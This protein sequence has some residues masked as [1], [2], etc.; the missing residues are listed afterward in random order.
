[1]ELPNTQVEAAISLA[2]G[3]VNEGRVQSRETVL[4]FPQVTIDDEHLFML[5]TREE[6]Q[7]YHNYHSRNARMGTSRRPTWTGI[8]QHG[9]TVHL[10]PAMELSDP[11]DADADLDADAME[12]QGRNVT[13]VP[14]LRTEATQPAFSGT[15]HTLDTEPSNESVPVVP[16]D[17]SHSIAEPKAVPKTP[18]PTLQMQASPKP[19]ESAA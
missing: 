11:P 16:T 5:S 14:P 17:T 3:L 13:P 19:A 12:A 7:V 10:Y 4:G 9:A 15:S 2:Q 18:P 6:A 1:M 8:D